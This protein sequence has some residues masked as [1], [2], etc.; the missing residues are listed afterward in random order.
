M[1][2]ATLPNEVLHLIIPNLDT[3]EDLSSLSQ[4][5][6]FF[7][8]V[9]L[10]T[11]SEG[12]YC[13]F[14]GSYPFSHQLLLAAV[15]AR[16]LA[17]WA[18]DSPERTLQLHGAINKGREGLCD[19]AVSVCP[20]TFDELRI[21]RM[22]AR[23][24]LDKAQAVVLE[25]KVRTGYYS[26]LET[27]LKARNGLL[28][29]HVY[30][31]LF[32]H[33]FDAQLTR[34][35]CQSQ[36]SIQAHSRYLEPQARDVRL[37]FLRYYC[38]AVEQLRYV[39]SPYYM[40]GHLIDVLALVLHCAITESKR[41][42]LQLQPLINQ[43]VPRGRGA[44][45]LYRHITSCG[46]DEV[47]ACLESGVLPVATK[48]LP[49]RLV[50]GELTVSSTR[51]LWLDDELGLIRRG[52]N[53]WESFPDLQS[54]PERYYSELG[55]NPSNEPWQ[56]RKPSKEALSRRA[57]G[58]FKKPYH[59]ICDEEEA[60]DKFITAPVGPPPSTAFLDCSRVG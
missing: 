10:A 25:D 14:I 2:L 36:A 41:E 4:T 28:D 29:I 20:L 24:V 45:R 53:R 19:L 23:N 46:L 33:A 5:S 8:D 12:L 58:Y 55:E 54:H 48:Q 26:Q 44:Y 30:T 31:Q 59:E 47:V 35:V 1:P 50:E 21:T 60:W 57:Y 39:D 3:L 56:L 11:L 43:S 15:K 27:N 22:W 51:L 16:Q 37:D 7:H 49:K 6:S 52:Y 9:C 40:F 42:N 18:V 38:G 34:L 13:L 32:H 17:D